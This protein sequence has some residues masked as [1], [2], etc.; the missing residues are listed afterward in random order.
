MLNRVVQNILYFNNKSSRRG[1]KRAS[2]ASHAKGIMT[3]TLPASLAGIFGEA[4]TTS[5]DDTRRLSRV[6]VVR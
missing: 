1:S 5:R 4:A 6:Y 2:D 3:T